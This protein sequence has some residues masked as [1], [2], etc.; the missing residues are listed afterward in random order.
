M[1]EKHMVDKIKK[2]YNWKNMIK[3]IIKIFFLLAIAICLI[4]A[5]F[6][7]TVTKMTPE[8]QERADRGELV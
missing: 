8:E 5:F 6:G 2:S 7:V 4:L 1:Q 3:G